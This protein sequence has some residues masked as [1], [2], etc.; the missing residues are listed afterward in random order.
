MLTKEQMIEELEGFALAWYQAKL[1]K[2]DLEDFYEGRYRGAASAFKWA[3]IVSYEELKA[4][5]EEAK[6]KA[7][8]EIG[9]A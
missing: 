5:E 4:I 9:E 8:N 6:A 7:E 2:S 1:K 3:G